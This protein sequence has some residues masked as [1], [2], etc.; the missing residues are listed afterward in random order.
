MYGEKFAVRCVIRIECERDEAAGITG[1]VV[2]FR[3]DFLE[4]DVNRERFVCS[5]EDVEVA[6]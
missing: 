2:E 5:A 1:I 6:I 3:K 4:V